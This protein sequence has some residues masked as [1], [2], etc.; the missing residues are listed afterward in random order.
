M[1][2]ENVKAS[3]HILALKNSAHLLENMEFSLVE[4]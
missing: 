4:N 2:P 3:C 1:V